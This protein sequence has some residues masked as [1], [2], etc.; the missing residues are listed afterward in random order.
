MQHIGSPFD[1]EREAGGNDDV[2][3]FFGI[4][5]FNGDLNGFFFNFVKAFEAGFVEEW[6]HA[7]NQNQTSGDFNIRCQGQNRQIRTFSGVEE[8]GQA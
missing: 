7:P 6:F 4:A 8:C 5:V 2:F 3:A 1:V